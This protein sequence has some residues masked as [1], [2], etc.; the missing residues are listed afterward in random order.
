MVFISEDGK[1]TEIKEM[2][3]D[4]L[5]WISEGELHGEHAHGKHVVVVKTG[6]GETIDILIDE[7]GK[8]ED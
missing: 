1:T 7:E 5:V 6:D 4:S 2:S 3:G 8:D